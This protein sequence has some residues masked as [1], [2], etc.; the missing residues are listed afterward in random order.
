MQGK[1]QYTEKLFNSFQLSERV[2]ENNFYRR[3]R[4][5]L[6]LRFVQPRTTHLYGV[7]GHPSIDSVVFF[8]LMLVGYLENISSDRKLIDHCSLRMDILFFLGYDIDEPLPWHSTVSRTRQIIDE[9]LFE[10]LFSHIY[11]MCVASGMVSGHTQAVDSAYIK[12]NASMESIE[13]K[14]APKESVKEFVQKGNKENLP[15]RQAGHQPQRKAKEN[16]ASQEQKTI[17]SSQKELRQLHSRNQYFKE[18]KIEEHGSK[19]ANSF[20]SYSN[21]THYSPTDPDARISTKPGKARQLNYLCNMAVDSCQGVITHIQADYADKKDSR[22]TMDMATKTKTELAK[23]NFIL[24]NILADTGYSSGINYH[25]LEKENIKAYIP[26]SG[27]YKHERDGF[28]YHKETDSFTCR[29]NKKLLHKKTYTNAAGS[30]MKSY[31]SSRKDCR[32]CPFKKTCLGKAAQEKK[33]ELSYYQEE[34]ERAWQRQQSKH[35]KHMV[36]VRAG[37]VEPVFGNLINYYGLKKINTKGI[38]GA[39]KCMLMSAIAFNLKKLMKFLSKKTNTKVQAMHRQPCAFL[40]PSLF[41][42]IRAVLRHPY[43]AAINAN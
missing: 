12:A 8:K 23:N 15:E 32:D 30:L 33:F 19:V 37:T 41:H 40:K 28:T 35:F 24:E 6:D 43:F 16:K 26:T 42:L 3:L 7:T 39:H 21:Q 31:R 27:V 4:Q 13:Q 36:R 18:N 22:Y 29:N 17:T 20:K 10:E 9:K 25:E 1:K 34:Y 11:S 2:P 5:K 38:K 14:Q